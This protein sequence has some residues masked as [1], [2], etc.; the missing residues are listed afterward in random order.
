MDAAVAEANRI[1]G[2]CTRC[3]GTKLHER[4]VAPCSVASL[5][6][7]LYFSL[8]RA[9]EIDACVVCLNDQMA[10]QQVVGINRLKVIEIGGDNADDRSIKCYTGDMSSEYDESMAVKWVLLNEMNNYPYEEIASK[11]WLVNVLSTKK[12][13]ILFEAIRLLVRRPCKELSPTVGQR[14]LRY[15]RILADYSLSYGDR[16]GYG[17][18]DGDGDGYG[19][20]DREYGYADRGCTPKDK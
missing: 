5:P 4:R 19:Y 2:E 1:N 15:P 7:S 12:H 20:D 9:N 10:L 18:G 16:Y 17:D 6:L 3:F 14:L 11:W 13:S 8:Q